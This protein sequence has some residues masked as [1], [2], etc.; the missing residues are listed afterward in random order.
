VTDSPFTAAFSLE[1]PAAHG[2]VDLAWVEAS[3][4]A[5]SRF[6]AALERQALSPGQTVV[7]VG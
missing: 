7:I 3:Q 4:K 5:P 2:K 1:T 6:L